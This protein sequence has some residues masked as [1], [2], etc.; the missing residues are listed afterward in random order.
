MPRK[1]KKP[2]VV[3][4][5]PSLHIGLGFGENDLIYHIKDRLFKDAAETIYGKPWVK[6]VWQQYDYVLLSNGAIL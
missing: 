3:A 2:V 4:L 5:I 1:K 6:R